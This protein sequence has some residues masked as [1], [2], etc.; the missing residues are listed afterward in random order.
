[1]LT[2]AG[3]TLALLSSP[4]FTGVLFAYY[5]MT[6]MYSL[7]LKRIVMIDVVMLAAL[8]TLRIIGGAI[9]IG[10]DLSFWLLAFSLFMFLSLALVKRYT[11]LAAMSGSGRQKIAGRGYDV[12]DLSLIQSLGAAAGY[13]SIL[14]FALYINS[15][16]SLE[17]YRNPRLLWLLCPVL[18]FWIGRI[19]IIAHRGGMHDD[20]IV[21]A[22]RDQV[23]WGVALVSICIIG[24]A[25]LSW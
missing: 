15:P 3:F 23:S 5:A 4:A 6:L 25:T 21:F 16:D 20:P 22:A 8:Y 1:M 14:V 18:L 24:G 17:L 11:E 13:V 7:V 19:W 12:S 9:A 10:V 2:L